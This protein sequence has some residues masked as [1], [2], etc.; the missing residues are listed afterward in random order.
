M[1]M[2]GNDPN[3]AL[4]EMK[5]KELVNILSDFNNLRDKETNRKFYLSE[6]KDKLCFLYGY[7]EE[8]IDLFMK[9]FNPKE[10]N[11]FYFNLNYIFSAF[12]F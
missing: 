5:V 2:E 8:L 7:N 12:N 11:Y 9:L 10:V 1:D 6:L 4:L 3:I